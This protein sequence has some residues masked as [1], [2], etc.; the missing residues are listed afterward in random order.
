MSK[1][2]RGGRRLSE[3]VRDGQR[4][5]EVVKDC[6]RWSEIDGGSQ[7][8]SKYVFKIFFGLLCIAFLGLA[9][10]DLRLSR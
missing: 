3:I 7:R 2:V 1:V 5:A 10:I 4:L 9:A 6:P 8:V